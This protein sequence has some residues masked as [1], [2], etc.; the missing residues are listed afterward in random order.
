MV[1]KR[2]KPNISSH[3][4]PRTLPWTLHRT[5]L[6]KCFVL[7]TLCCK[8]KH[9]KRLECFVLTKLCWIT[10]N[11]RLYFSTQNVYINVSMWS[12]NCQ[13][14]VYVTWEIS[15]RLFGKGQLIFKC[16]FWCLQLIPKNE[17][18]TIWLEVLTKVQSKFL[19]PFFR[20][21]KMPKIRFEINWPL[22]QISQ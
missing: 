2:L 13:K 8:T 6:L 14:H 11:T 1:S 15:L 4:K 12:K 21:L 19:V 10:R 9:L 16:L 5:R 17:K 18:K 22:E 7:F 3:S 20:E